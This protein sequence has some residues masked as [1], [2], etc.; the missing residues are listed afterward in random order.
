MN[1]L[2]DFEQIV[3]P[4]QG[5]YGWG[6]HYGGFCI[7]MYGPP[8]QDHVAVMQ[9]ERN[10][11]EKMAESGEKPGSGFHSSQQHGEK[12]LPCKNTRGEEHGPAHVHVIDKNTNRES[13]FELVEN[14]GD[15]HAHYMRLLPSSN[16]AYH[17]NNGKKNLSGKKKRSRKPAP[18]TEAQIEAVTPILNAHAERF[19]QLWREFYADKRISNYV[20]RVSE[21]LSG[22]LER[23]RFEDRS[24][25][26]KSIILEDSRG[27]KASMP[28]D[29]YITFA[30]HVKRNRPKHR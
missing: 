3:P 29:D 11:T 10:L 27:Q 18:L 22:C 30:N 12:N 13:K 5:Q 7:V 8:E 1:K 25:T 19:I 20:T 26:H 14:I 9:A 24:L 28:F 15:N 2:K 17:E 16:D 21:K 23:V 6:F 4:Q